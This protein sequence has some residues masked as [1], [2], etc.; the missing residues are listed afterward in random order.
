MYVNRS[1]HGKQ[2]LERLKTKSSDARW[3]KWIADG[4]K[5]TKDNTGKVIQKMIV[6][7][8]SKSL[9][10]NDQTDLSIHNPTSIREIHRR[11]VYARQTLNPLGF[12]LIH[13]QS[14]TGIANL[15]K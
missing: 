7:M 12:S 11:P 8:C 15:I 1:T 3:K 9:L 14:R 10:L 2:K 13:V 4:M 6:F 5:G